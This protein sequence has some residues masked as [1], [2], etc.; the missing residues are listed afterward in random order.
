MKK[1]KNSIAALAV[2]F[3]GTFAV[4]APVGVVSAYNPLD[5]VCKNGGA[6]EVCSNRN[7]KAEDTV[8]KVV[9]LLLF[10]V[11]GLAVVMIIFSGIFYVISQGDAGRVAKA[12]NT[13]TYSVVGLIIAFLAFAIVNW[14]VGE[15]K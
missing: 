5:D 2:F 7:E 8:K 1:I 6:T 12:K 4:L 15:F 10:V 11:G 13:L 3:V 14:V 9:N